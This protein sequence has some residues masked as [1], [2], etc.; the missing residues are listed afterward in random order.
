MPV[1]R[2]LLVSFHFFTSSIVSHWHRLTEMIT[3]FE[4]DRLNWRQKIFSFLQTNILWQMINC[5]QFSQSPV[6]TK[7]ILE[8]GGTE[9]RGKSKQNV[10]RG[11][12][13]RKDFEAPFLR[14]Q[15]QMGSD[16]FGSDALFAGRLYGIGSRTVRVTRDWIHNCS[17]SMGSDPFGFYELLATLW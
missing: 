7:F 14:D 1:L 5:C 9:T 8:G 10:I 17:R 4:I 12:R 15:I 11:P 2:F 3:N 13:L 16:P 6:E